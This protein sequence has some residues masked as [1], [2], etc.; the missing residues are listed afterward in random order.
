L[1]FIF[2][3]RF[4][5]FFAFKLCDREADKDWR[6]VSR[7]LCK[8][9]LR[10][11]WQLQLWMLDDADRP[12]VS[13]APHTVPVV[14]ARV[15]A[16]QLWPPLRARRS[17]AGA[18]PAPPA[19][20]DLPGGP[21]A[22]E[23]GELADD[24]LIDEGVGDPDPD[25]G[26]DGP[27]PDEDMPRTLVAL[28][29]SAFDLYIDDDDG[30][31]D[32]GDDHE[33]AARGKADAVFLCP[34]GRISYYLNKLDFEAV[35]LCPSH[36][37]HTRCVVTRQ[38]NKYAQKSTDEVAWIG[39]RPLGLLV[40][41]LARSEPHDDRVAH[42]EFVRLIEDDFHVRMR[43]RQHAMTLPGWAQIQQFERQLLHDDELAIE[44]L[45]VRVM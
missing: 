36:S 23:D 24:L 28:L 42:R 11:K 26:G 9:D 39:G 15:L 35:C 4:C 29:A 2:A 16:E 40:A 27:G 33:P 19:G 21:L 17:A 32:E 14:F 45:H 7:A 37:T 31:D 22:I 30:I 10:R 41:W 18:A 44:P 3:R 6:V 25:C 34:G 1:L 8:L 43:S 5:M 20:D 38:S 12:V 13:I